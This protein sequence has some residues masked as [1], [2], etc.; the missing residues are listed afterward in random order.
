MNRKHG[1]IAALLLLVLAVAAGVAEREGSAELPAVSVEKS[2]PTVKVIAHRG[3]AANA[4]ENTL[5]ALELGIAQGADM[6]EMDLHMTKD[7][8][9]VALHDHTLTRTT[10]VEQAVGEMDSLQIREL[11]AGG[12]FSPDYAGEQIPTL[13]ELLGVAGGRI[14]L[15]LEFKFP[16]SQ[17]M[18]EEAMEQIQAAGMESECILAATSPELLRLG[19]ELAPEMENL[20]IGEQIGEAL[21]ETEYVDSFSIALSGLTAEAVARA[22]S[23]G[24]EVYAWTVNSAREMEQALSMGV[25]GLVTDDPALA[26]EVLRGR[27]MEEK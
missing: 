6:A 1:L 24:R 4:P 3:G 11:D 26:W 14:G 13:E 20:Y 25:D 27:S 8:V 17:A 9:L 12:W 16:Q 18:L 22:H 10:G 21:W 19:K 5:A 7:G 2:A 23:T 15:M